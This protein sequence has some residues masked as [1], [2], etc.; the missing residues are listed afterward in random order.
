MYNNKPILLFGLPRSGTTWLGKILDSHPDTL[1]RHEPDRWGKINE[2]PLVISSSD[3][4]SYAP[5]ILDFVE[6]LANLNHSSVNGKLPAFPKSYFS[7]NQFL[8]NQTNSWLS[9][10]ICLCFGEIPL[11]HFKNYLAVP[12]LRIIWK[13]IESL[14]RLGAIVTSLKECRA[15]HLVRHPCGY[16]LSV[17]RGES[18]R[19]FTGKILTSEDWPVFEMLLSTTLARDN[20]LSLEQ[21]RQA[22]P[23]ERMAWRWALFND[24]ALDEISGMDHCTTMLYEDFCRSP[25]ASVR[26]LLDFVDL[27]WNAQIERFLLRSTSFER[28][29]YYS[30]FKIS[31]KAADKWRDELSAEQ[32]DSIMRIAALSRTGKMYLNSASIV[33]ASS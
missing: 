21:L 29:G 5:I 17:Q 16:V 4:N 8:I 26:S 11:P 3:P 30:I 10:L 1:Y 18:A 22:S 33:P 6:R 32:I 15:I 20:G 13:S 24:K 12:H 2:L 19:K 7:T 9:K 28:Y 25:Q 23:V 14:G 31:S 27:D